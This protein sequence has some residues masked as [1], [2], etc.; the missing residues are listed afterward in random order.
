[1]SHGMRSSPR[2]K[3]VTRAKK[4]KFVYRDEDGLIYDREPWKRSSRQLT[5]E[6]LVAMVERNT[7]IVLSVEDR[8]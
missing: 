1:M 5:R 4:T 7:V 2:S 3:P 8:N 6:E